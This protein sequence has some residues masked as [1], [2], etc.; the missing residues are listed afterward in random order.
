MTPEQ[1]ARLRTL[2]EREIDAPGS[3]T[4]LRA[5][6]EAA[7]PH[8]AP[9]LRFWAERDEEH[10]AAFYVRSESVWYRRFGFRMMRPLF[11]LGVLAA[12]GFA[13]QRAIDPVLGLA[14]FLAG[15]FGFYALLQVFAHR[16]SKRDLHRLDE[17]RA[18]YRMRL[19][20]LRDELD[21]A[22]R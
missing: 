3:V 13:L 20:A 9:V 18:A 19:E 8:L 17:I 21:E 15:A 12:V 14:S 7:F 6:I 2:L 4:E 22:G 16:W 5:D 10:R 1:R 11:V